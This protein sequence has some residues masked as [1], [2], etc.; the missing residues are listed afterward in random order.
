MSIKTRNNL[1]ASEKQQNPI[2]RCKTRKILDTR[3]ILSEKQML[4]DTRINIA[5]LYDKQ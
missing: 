3:K 4:E 2:F 5:G 1:N